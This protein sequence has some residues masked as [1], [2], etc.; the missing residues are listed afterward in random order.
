MDQLKNVLL[1]DMEVV[2]IGGSHRY[3]SPDDLAAFFAPPNEDSYNKHIDVGHIA[4]FFLGDAQGGALVLH[5][6][7]I[8]SFE[9]A[10]EAKSMAHRTGA[11]IDL[12]EAELERRVAK[13]FCDQTVQVADAIGWFP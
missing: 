13:L 5:F 1:A 10:Q 6:P 8:D 3:Y 4:D 12:S 9:M 11:F 7:A 2:V